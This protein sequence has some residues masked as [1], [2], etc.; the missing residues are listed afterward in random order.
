M[1]CGKEAR[2]GEIIGTSVNQF[3]CQNSSEVQKC[4][5]QTTLSSWS[6]E[7]ESGA[8]STGNLAIGGVYN[9]FRGFNLFTMHDFHP[10][11]CAV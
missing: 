3:C 2:T 1:F 9:E 5:H 7:G 11:I 8:E 6:V 10:T 4:C